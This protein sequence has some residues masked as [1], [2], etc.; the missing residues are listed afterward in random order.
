MVYLEPDRTLVSTVRARDYGAAAASYCRRRSVNFIHL[1]ITIIIR[2][3]KKP[4]SF[5]LVTDSGAAIS[6]AGE[7]KWKQ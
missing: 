1:K 5:D 7:E 2:I 4:P 6:S 3:G